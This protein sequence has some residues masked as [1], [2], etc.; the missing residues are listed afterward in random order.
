MDH[1]QYSS[2]VSTSG[3]SGGTQRCAVQATASGSR[4]PSSLSHMH[5]HTRSVLGPRFAS[6][7]SA[8]T[9]TASPANSVEPALVASRSSGTDTCTCVLLGVVASLRPPHPRARHALS[10]NKGSPRP[11]SKPSRSTSE[12][13]PHLVLRVSS[14]R[15]PPHAPSVWLWLHLARRLLDPAVDVVY[16]HGSLPVCNIFPLRAPYPDDRLDCLC[17]RFVGI[18]RFE[19]RNL[20]D[21]HLVPRNAPVCDRLVTPPICIVTFLDSW[22][23]LPIDLVGIHD[24][25]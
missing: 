14:L 9:R 18:D 7:R 8:H 2:T 19:Q 5:T 1:G 6:C 21:P 20:L 11:P 25:C 13:Q 24:L 3:T 23:P 10:L 4:F 22:S 12:T 15:R 16:C 17:A